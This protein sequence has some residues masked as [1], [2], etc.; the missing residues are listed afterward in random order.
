MAATVTKLETRRRRTG[1][2]GG[3]TMRAAIDAFLDTPKVKGTPKGGR[4]GGT[5]GSD[6]TPHRHPS[7]SPPG[8]LVGRDHDALRGRH[9]VDE[10]E[11]GWGEAVGEQ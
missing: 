10:V 11:R 4:R 5:A 3:P 6:R 9:A 2:G 7:S 1:K 8:R